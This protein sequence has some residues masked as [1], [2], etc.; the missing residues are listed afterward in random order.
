MIATRVGGVFQVVRHNETGLLVPPSDSESLG[1]RILE[2]LNDPLKA[3]AL[4]REAR[5]E[6]IREFS[7]EKMV[8]K[9]LDVYREVLSEDVTTP[10]PERKLI[11]R[12]IPSA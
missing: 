3:R 4:G 12:G 6:V 8:S 2:L 10:S 1:E 7:V 5:A 11:Y 9:T